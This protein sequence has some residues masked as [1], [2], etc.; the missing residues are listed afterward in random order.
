M[1]RT[2][3]RVDRP[4]LISVMVLMAAGFVIFI[5]ASLG[6]LAKSS[7]QYSSVTFSQAVL[8]LA[9]GSVAMVIVS[10]LDYK[11]WKKWAF[12]LFVAAVILNILVLIPHIGFE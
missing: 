5:S 2:K 3:W 1:A 11:V 9:L 10:R 6:L 12:W 4:F 8:G 7:S